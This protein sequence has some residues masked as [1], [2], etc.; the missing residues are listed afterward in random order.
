MHE[1]ADEVEQVGQLDAVGRLQI[2]GGAGWSAPPAC[3]RQCRLAAAAAQQLTPVLLQGQHVINKDVAE[4]YHEEGEEDEEVDEEEEEEEEEEEDEEE[5][6]QE[7]R[8]F[9]IYQCLPVDDAEPDWES[10]EA[11][12]VEEYLRR[13]RWAW[14]VS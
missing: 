14:D 1:S 9:G 5:A 3:R 10:G 2:V 4:E 11:A 7:R 13:V 12:T 6:E 8:E